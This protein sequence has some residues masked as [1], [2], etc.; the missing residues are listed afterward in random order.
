MQVKVNIFYTKKS[1]HGDHNSL[2]TSIALH[3]ASGMHNSKILQSIKS[4]TVQKLKC[5]LFTLLSFVLHKKLVKT[6]CSH[7]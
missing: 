7:K 4:K 3:H 2:W 6:D 5:Y 1:W